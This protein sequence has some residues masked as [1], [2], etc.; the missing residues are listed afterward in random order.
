MN[1]KIFLIIITCVTVLCILVGSFMH[2]GYQRNAFR[3]VGRNV[4]RAIR[5]SFRGVKNGDYSD[6]DLEYDFDD[7]DD[8]DDSDEDWVGKE[9]KSAELEKFETIDINGSVMAVKIERGNSYSIDVYYAKKELRP[10]YKVTG[11]VLKINQ[12]DYK[13]GRSTN[14]K[15]SVV[16]KVPFGAKIDNIKINVDVGAIE[17][18]NIDTEDAEINTD[19]G[20]ISIDNVVFENLK[21]NS[22]VGAV[23]ISLVD[24]INNY[25]IDAKTQLGGIEVSGRS[26]KRKYTQKGTTS[27]NI[28]IKTEV[29]GIDIN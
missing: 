1:K 5:N 24:D 8:I 7:F 26:A 15:C 23:S 18:K 2:L 9:S 16:I 12:P 21:A 11:Q 4:S 13:S 3:S 19:V 22:D 25:G 20:A 14:G 6:S 17:L 10:A 27:K 29:G 28:K